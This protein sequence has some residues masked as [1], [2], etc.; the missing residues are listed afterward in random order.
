MGLCGGALC[1]SIEDCSDEVALRGGVGLTVVSVLGGESAFESGVVRG[2]RW[3]C[4]KGVAERNLLKTARIIGSDDVE[5]G[6]APPVGDF[7]EEAPPG[8]LV[9]VGIN[10]MPVMRS[11]D[12]CNRLGVV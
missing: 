11:E 8:P 2:Q 5:V 1:R 3:I 12:R 6:A 9:Q 7:D 10:V 4:A